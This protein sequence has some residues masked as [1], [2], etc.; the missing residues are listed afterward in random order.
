MNTE[1]LI[2]DYMNNVI[3]PRF[4]KIAKQSLDKSVYD[5]YE[6]IIYKRK[7]SLKNNWVMKKTKRG[8]EFYIS[9]NTIG[10]YKNKN[11]Y[12]PYILEKGWVRRTGKDNKKPRPIMSKLRK[13]LKKDRLIKS[14]M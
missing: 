3:F 13:D 9:E 8:Y 5:I 4:K 12:L 10:S 6:P 1:K 11:Y 7:Y 14:M 2:D